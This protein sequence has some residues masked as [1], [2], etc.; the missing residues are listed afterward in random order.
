MECA[1]LNTHNAQRSL[2]LNT[3][4]MSLNQ[5]LNADAQAWADQL[6]ETQNFAHDFTIQGV[7]GENIYYEGFFGTDVEALKVQAAA[8][9]V[10]AWYGEIVDYNWNDDQANMDNFQAIGH[11]TQVVWDDSVSLGMGA[12]HYVDANNGAVYVYVVGR[13][14]SPGNSG[15]FS[16]H[17]HTECGNECSQQCSADTTT[18]AETTTAMDTT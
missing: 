13:Y 9:A 3:P 10:M 11:F 16:G 1:G 18:V 8:N 7:Q 2:H 12:A 6:A 17:V 14:Q 15:T 4:C 5:N